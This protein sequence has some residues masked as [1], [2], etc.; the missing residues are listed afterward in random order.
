MTHSRR[1][2][3]PEWA[4]T[5]LG[6]R[7]Y[8]D[9]S[10]RWEDE[11]LERRIREEAGPVVTRQR[12]ERLVPR[13]GRRGFNGIRVHRDGLEVFAGIRDQI[14]DKETDKCHIDVDVVDKKLVITQAEDGLWSFSP[15]QQYR[16]G[17]RRLSEALVERGMQ[18]GMYRATVED[19][20]RVVV[21]FADGPVEEAGT[22]VG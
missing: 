12:F 20:Q 11:L 10:D 9:E 15:T 16:I 7:E 3:A 13:M 4:D 8:M 5:G 21:S 18:H 22:L 2:H 17:G 19:G 14:T 6:T 1:R